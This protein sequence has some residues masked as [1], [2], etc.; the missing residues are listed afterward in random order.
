M[1]NV[2]KAST[3]A[4]HFPDTKTANIEKKRF[5]CAQCDFIFVMH[6]QSVHEGLKFQFQPIFNHT[7]SLECDLSKHK[8]MH[9][10]FIQ[11]VS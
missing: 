3:T 2:S 8:K 4:V 1:L 10:S 11:N 7:V 9:P 5:N 6:K